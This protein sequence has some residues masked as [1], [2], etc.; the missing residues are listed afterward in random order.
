MRKRRSS[1]SDLS[2]LFFCQRH[3]GE[4]FLDER[5]TQRDTSERGFGSITSACSC[6]NK[7]I[8]AVPDGTDNSEENQLFGKTLQN[9]QEVGLNS[10]NQAATHTAANLAETKRPPFHVLPSPEARWN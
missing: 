6:R 10:P 2:L 5:E 8:D 3:S 1:R 4:I 7:N 9:N